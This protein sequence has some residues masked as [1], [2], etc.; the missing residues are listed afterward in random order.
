MSGTHSTPKDPIRSLFA[1]I[2]ARTG[3]TRFPKKVL[4]PLPPGSETTI[5]DHLHSRVSQVLPE[6]RI[7]YLIPEGDS[8][9]EEFL[10][11][12]NRLHFSG[13]LEDVR[14][15][16]ILAANR[17][18]A[19]GILRLTGD[20]PFYDVLHLDLLLQTFSKGECDLAYFKGLPLGTG[21]EIFRK[22]ALEW[23][24]LSGLKEHHREHVSLHIKEDP[25]KFRIL[26]IPSII[27]EEDR[28]KIPNFR[29]TVDTP[30]DFQTLA[31]ILEENPQAISFGT[32][33]FLE[34]EKKEPEL[35]L[36][37]K[38][39]PQ[40]RFPLPNPEK[41]VKG[42]IG[43]LIAPEREYGSGHFVRSSLLFSLLPYRDW[44]PVLLKTFPEDGEFQI[45]L[46]DHR[47]IEIPKEYRI[48]KLLLLDH[49]GRDR[50]K[51]PYWDLLPHPENEK[52]F[53]WN[54][55]LIPPA[56]TE[57][58]TVAQHG[59]RKYDLFCYAGTLEEK[60]SQELDSFFIK[61][62]SG[63]N[64]YRVGGTPPE[65][66]TEIEYSPRLSRPSY[67]SAL[68]S[69]KT[70]LGYFGQS[71][72]EALYLRIPSA[73]Y[74]ISPVHRKLSELLEKDGIP[75]TDFGSLPKFSLGQKSVNGKGY[76]LLLDRIDF[77]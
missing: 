55:I 12:R 65:P 56:L 43:M 2:Q 77:L 14:E 57:N 29:L 59:S 15:R 66:K 28:T 5:L 42:K 1:F 46:I 25:E 9:L 75:F 45:L 37:N 38:D 19:D 53:D 13:P 74:S 60:E 71:L 33:E 35:F 44:E 47:D 20:N 54:R 7:V 63:K 21:G 41:P 48:T 22:T 3:S 67:L 69:S 70:F 51:Y 62:F 34:L 10:R 31:R 26:P 73:S 61:Y 6:S 72:F 17:F 18:D 32:R 36:A 11:K 27:P 16:Y 52:D 24:P 40:V 4:A 64:V 8:E 68:S 39:V 58:H 50:K 76:D 23:V 30:Q 49:F